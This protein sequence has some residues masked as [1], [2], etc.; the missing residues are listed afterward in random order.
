MIKRTCKL[1]A[2]TI[3]LFS[4]ANLQAF[5]SASGAD[6]LNTNTSTR[7]EGM[8]AADVSVITDIS[9]INTNP[10]SLAFLKVPELYYMHKTTLQEFHTE[11]VSMGVPFALF[12]RS[13]KSLPKSL[14][15]VRKVRTG[16]SVLY[17]HTPR[18]DVFGNESNQSIG[19]VGA[20]D[21]A[22]SLGFGYN[23]RG[24]RIGFTAKYINRALADFTAQAFAFD[25]GIL[26]GFEVPR[27]LPYQRRYN[28]R[29]GFAVKNAGTP[30]KFNSESE[31][32]P[33]QFKPGF[34]YGIFGNRDHM[35]DLSFG[36]T[37]IIEESISTNVGVEYRV[38]SAIFFRTGLD[39]SGD[40]AVFTLGTGGKYTFRKV[41]YQLDYAFWSRANGVPDNHTVSLMAKF[42]FF[43][44]GKKKRVT[45]LGIIEGDTLDKSNKPKRKRKIKIKKK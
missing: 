15:W 14:R 34:T 30:I 6:F 25:F 23:L 2:I 18:I 40:G 38:F 16:V 28:L 7:S 8:G 1:F 43:K 13:R 11:Y 37:Q 5:N 20:Q 33:I 24:Y 26:K 27:F 32:L 39:I 31:N 21:T 22:V 45:S 3:V 36:M 10:A 9:G 12:F 41:T 17:W 44:V 35:V 29:V 42:R 4:S 19:T